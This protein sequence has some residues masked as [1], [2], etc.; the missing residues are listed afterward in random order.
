[1]NEKDMGWLQKI[2]RILGTCLKNYI[3]KFKVLRND[4]Q[5]YY[6]VCPVTKRG[7]FVFRKLIIINERRKYV[8]DSNRM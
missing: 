5:E 2:L 4:I 8:V 6:Q 7:M 3:I 1:M